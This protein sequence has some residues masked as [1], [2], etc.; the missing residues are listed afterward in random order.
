M[1]GPEQSA[2]RAKGVAV[3][4]AARTVTPP[5]APASTPKADPTPQEALPVKQV[6]RNVAAR[7]AVSAGRQVHVPEPASFQ[8]NGGFDPA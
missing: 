6:K 1:A 3:V 4:A 5:S 8:P 7:R 2:T